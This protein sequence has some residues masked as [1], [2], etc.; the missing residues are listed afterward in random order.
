[1]EKGFWKK[2]LR[3][4]LAF[5]YIGF[6]AEEVQAQAVVTDTQ[7][8]GK[9]VK[10]WFTEV[11]ESKTVVGTMQTVQKTSTAIGTAKKSVSEYVVANKEKIEEKVA[12]VQEYQ[13]KA[14]EYKK[15]YDQYKKQ[16]DENITK[17]KELKEQAE[18][19]V[20]TAKE[21]ASAAQ[22][23]ADS[24]LDAAKDKAGI[25]TNKGQEEK[26]DTEVDVEADTTD[27]VTD[28]NESVLI[29]AQTNTAK[30]NAAETDPTSSRIPFEGD[31]T[32]TDAAGTDAAG[33][34]AAGTDA[35]GTDAAGTDAAGTDTDAAD[36]DAADTDAKI[37]KTN[38]ELS[39][40]LTEEEQN[41]FNQLESKDSLSEEETQKLNALKAKISQIQNKQVSVDE[42]TASKATE[43]EVAIM[44]AKSIK[45]QEKATI[46]SAKTKAVKDLSPIETVKPSVAVPTE[47]IQLRKA[48]TTSS[49]HHS[50]TLMFAKVELLN[51]PDGGTDSNGTVIIPRALAMYCGLSS[52]D[53]LE[54]NKMDECLLKLNKEKQSA[55]LFSGSDAPKVYNQAL[56]QYVAASMAEAYKARQDADSFEENFIDAVEFA[57]ELDAQAVYDNIVELNKAIDM[58]MN[59][60][61][62]VFSSQLMVQSLYNYGS[63]SFVPAESGDEDE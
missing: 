40:I 47:H 42:T 7:S 46:D 5:L 60:L 25:S 19:G 63:Y 2:L 51:L 53:A 58:Q 11:K 56:A 30:E 39:S 16:L 38:N 54:E 48:F 8:T 34:D 57:P 33:T 45:Q 31:N 59:G 52:S 37:E 1:M 4:F 29:D 10:Q 9:T 22:D 28:T 36:T 18:E 23:V 3:G 6:C 24:K 32:G 21:T 49:L 43:A 50:E 27:A 26:A 15:E 44:E 55:Q 13:K 12:K 35:A 14:E 20:E 41:T 61:L 62:K 17:A